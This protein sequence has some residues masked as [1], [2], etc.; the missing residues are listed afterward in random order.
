M[1]NFIDKIK[2]YFQKRQLRKEQKILHKYV[3]LMRRYNAAKKAS[4]SI[5][6]TT[7]PVP[8]LKKM[9]NDVGVKDV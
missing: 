6:M 7:P 8:L 3:E 1:F 9:L 4:Q 2:W 5:T